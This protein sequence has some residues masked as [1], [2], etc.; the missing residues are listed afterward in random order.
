VD[1]YTVSIRPPVSFIHCQEVFCTMGVD[2]SARKACRQVIWARPF[3]ANSFGEHFTDPA[4]IEKAT[5]T[6][7]H[8]ICDEGQPR[9]V[10]C[11]RA[12]CRVLPTLKQA[13]LNLAHRQTASA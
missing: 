13:V 9:S 3:V 6:L 10:L 2:V 8:E 4:L 12:F 1:G 5:D 11:S 7:P